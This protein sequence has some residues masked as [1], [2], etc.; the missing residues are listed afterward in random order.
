MR[1]IT[2]SRYFPKKHPKVGASTFFVEQIWSGLLN[3]L[4]LNGRQELYKISKSLPELD[5]SWSEKIIWNDKYHTIRAGN[6]WKIG[7]MFSPRI[8]SGNP[9]RS[10]QIQFAPPIEIKKIWDIEMYGMTTLLN[11]KPIN[12]LTLQ[13]IAK[14][15]GL[16][17]K[18]FDV[19]FDPLPFKG[20]II[21]W[22]ENINY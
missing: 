18:D 3:V 21:C 19:W 6:R 10:K 16:N 12:S 9:Y 13:E 17:Y 7:D 2:F 1:V 20:Q 4:M 11:D 5:K 14:N 8:W 22:N 15:D